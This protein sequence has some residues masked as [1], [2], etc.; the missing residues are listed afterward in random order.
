M[1]QLSTKWAS[2]GAADT[3]ARFNA[4]VGA[5]I[6]TR[7]HELGLSL[8]P[9]AHALR[10][11]PVTL[12]RYEKGAQSLPAALLFYLSELLDVPPEYF[13]PASFVEFKHLDEE[14]CRV[15]H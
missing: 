1:E 10:V 5:R 8:G 11:S 13:V 4:Y 9:T 12:R 3:S 6:S 2:I 15:L 7:R 14:M